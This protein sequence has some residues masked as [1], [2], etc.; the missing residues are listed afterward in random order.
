MK[1]RLE[2]LEKELFLLEMKD[3]WNREDF[4]KSAHLSHE[5]KEIKKNLKRG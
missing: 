1:E 5:I 4:D 3:R 2:R